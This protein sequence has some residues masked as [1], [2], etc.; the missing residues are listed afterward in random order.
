MRCSMIRAIA[1]TAYVPRRAWATRSAGSTTTVS[2]ASVAC[3]V[4]RLPE[5]RAAELRD[6]FMQEKASHRRKA[7]AYWVTDRSQTEAQ[8]W[9]L[10]KE[11][12]QFTNPAAGSEDPTLSEVQALYQSACAD[13]PT[14]E[15]LLQR[16][17]GRVDFIG[18]GIQVL[19]DEGI[20]L[21]ERFS[22]DPV[23]AAQELYE[24]SSFDPDITLTHAEA[25]LIENC[26]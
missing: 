14:A 7:C 1:R 23:G 26:G 2:S 25:A 13:A 20:D 16:Q 9:K 19:R 12:F 10:W 3:L 24:P 17:P 8:Q 21:C 15:E 6:G 11:N 18:A 4:E 22:S 5:I